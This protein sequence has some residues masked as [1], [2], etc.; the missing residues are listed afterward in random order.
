MPF[1]DEDSTDSDGSSQN[2]GSSPQS[3]TTNATSVGTNDD[4]N[5]CHKRKRKAM[6]VLPHKRRR[7]EPCFD[8]EAL[9]VDG[10]LGSTTTGM[11]CMPRKNQG[12]ELLERLALSD[13]EECGSFPASVWRS[14]FVYLP[15]RS[16]G[17]LLSV[18]SMFYRL[19]TGSSPKPGGG[20]FAQDTV[21][22]DAERIW[23]MAR[24]RYHPHLPRP[25]HGYRELDMWRLIGATQCQFCVQSLGSPLQSSNYLVGNHLTYQGPTCAEIYWPLA[26]RSCQRCLGRQFST[27]C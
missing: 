9:P 19:L 21:H 18:N 10:S 7:M 4:S 17:T 27:V 24:Q 22:K 6:D 20:P 25:L 11:P 15:P 3:T 23:T 2:M 26:V 8:E 14:I 5:G 1:M 13:A 12:D 16:L